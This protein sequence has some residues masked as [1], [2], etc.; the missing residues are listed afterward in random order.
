[1]MLCQQITEHKEKVASL[2]YDDK[3]IQQTLMRR[4]AKYTCVNDQLRGHTDRI[5]A[6]F[7]FWCFVDLNFV[8]VYKNTKKRISQYPVIVTSA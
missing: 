8:L 3:G 5:V 6:L 2:N 1:M 7:F 4:Q